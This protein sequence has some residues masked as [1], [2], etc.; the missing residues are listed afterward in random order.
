MT[1]LSK[2]TFDWTFTPFEVIVLGNFTLDGIVTGLLQGRTACNARRVRV[3]MQDVTSVTWFKIGNDRSDLPTGKSMTLPNVSDHLDVVLHVFLIVDGD[4]QTVWFPV[5]VAAFFRR[6]V[7]VVSTLSISQHYLQ[8]QSLTDPDASRSSL[9]TP[10]VH[11]HR[12]GSSPHRNEASIDLAVDA[13]EEKE[14]HLSS[15][16]AW[17]PDQIHLLM[18]NPALYDPL[19]KPRYPIVLCHG[20]FAPYIL[21]VFRFVWIA[22][23]QDEKGWDLGR[24]SKHVYESEVEPCPAPAPASCES[25][26]A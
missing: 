13:V 25:R 2:V 24:T 20:E 3:P 10:R 7:N 11:G 22:G 21:A 6:L 17:T 26:R 8:S 16:A 1:G 4:M 18:N 14:A 23:S 12:R 9:P 15:S 5:P 19:R